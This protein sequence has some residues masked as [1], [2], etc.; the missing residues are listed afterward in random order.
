MNILDTIELHVAQF[1]QRSLEKPL[2][3][4]ILLSTEDKDDL[5]LELLKF[6]LTLKDTDVKSY[7]GVEVLFS[8]TLPSGFVETLTK[9]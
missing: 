5:K 9:K 7:R 6:G 3:D 8:D 2:P 1:S 4:Y